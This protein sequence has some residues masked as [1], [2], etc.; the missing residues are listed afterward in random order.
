MIVQHNIS[1]LN[2]NR[3]LNK[4]SGALKKN[5]EK[6]SS[7]FR[8]NRSADDAAGL[9]ISEKMRAS[10]AA[11]DQAELNAQDGIS[12][13]QT[14]DGAMQEIHNML[15]RMGSLAAQAA[16]GTLSDE[17][18]E[19]IQLEIDA[20]LKEIT[21]I[22]NDTEFNEIPL[23][24]GDEAT[25]TTPPVIKGGLPA[26]VGTSASDHLSDEFVTEYDYT[27][28]TTDPGT[29]VVTGTTTGTAE[30][31]HEAVFIDFSNLVADPADPNYNLD[32]LLDADTGFYST[33][34]TCSNH[35]SIK[36][37]DGGGNSHEGSGDHHIYNV[38]ISGVTSAE[39]LINAIMSATASSDGDGIPNGHYTEFDMLPTDPDQ[40]YDPVT[41][42][43]TT[44]V[45][46]DGRSNISE[47]DILAN[48]GITVPADSELTWDTSTWRPYTNGQIAQANG[49]YGK[50]GKGVAY[51]ARTADVGEVVLQIGDGDNGRMKIDL[52][53]MALTRIGVYGMDVSTV[54]GAQAALGTIKSGVSYVGQERGRMGAYQNRL[55]HACNNL[56]VT[57]ENLTQS[58]SVI[59]D[60]NIADEM[61]AYTKNNIL[62]QSAQAMLAQSNQVPQGVLQLMQ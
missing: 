27:I 12:L 39:D 28:T 32:E 30:V 55:E 57:S 54:A 45:M 33:C 19:K 56:G 62:I 13:V 6:L 46:F 3:N 61:M 8:I 7:G 25:A 11:L 34:C 41:N 18:R 2:A 60:T 40:P 59:R 49:S 20:I 24:Q 26:W 44:L 58:E 36:F 9:A 31:P 48:N 50:F 42:P 1:A 47:D 15:T 14:A 35:Y 29:G 53:N 52:P 21:R 16:N 38:D 4:N 37:V 51:D 10:I 22:K 43:Y 5:L 17:D 23:L